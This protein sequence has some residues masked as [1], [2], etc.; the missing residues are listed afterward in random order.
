MIYTITFNPALDISGTVDELIPNEKTYVHNELHTPGGNGINVAMIAQRL[1]A[2]VIA[3]GFLGGPNGKEISRLLKIE[4]LK[5]SFV[6]IAGGTR[7]N[8]TVAHKDTLKQT[9]LSFSGPQISPAEFAKLDLYLKKSKKNDLAV[10]GGSLPPGIKTSHLV[11][12]IKKAKERGSLCLVDI[13][14][15]NLKQVLKAKPFFIKPNLVEFQKLCSCKAETIEEILPLV[16]TLNKFVPLICVSSV[17]GG[18]LLVSS[19]EAWYG[20][21]PEVQIRSSVGAGDSMVGAICTVLERDRNAPLEELLRWGLAAACATL[22]EPGMKLGS[23]KSIKKFLPQISL[24][25]M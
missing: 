1:G 7:M 10:F 14:A 21:I 15:E 23:K 8:L 9:R 5:H 17:E 13:P 3:T 12:L 2:H 20:K 25:K 24:K 11:T 19:D 22:T 6:S 18:A 16:R 4:G